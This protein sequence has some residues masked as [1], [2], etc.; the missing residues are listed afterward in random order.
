MP[1]DID[2]DLIAAY[3]V[4]SLAVSY[5]SYLVTPWVVLLALCVATPLVISKLIR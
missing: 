1:Q 5:Y 4:V 2:L 3:S